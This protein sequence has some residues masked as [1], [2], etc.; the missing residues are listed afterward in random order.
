MFHLLFPNKETITD[1]GVGLYW[2]PRLSSK[3]YLE[4]DCSEQFMSP[5]QGSC[6]KVPELSM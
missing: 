6:T 2:M 4:V 3:V 1:E 5:V